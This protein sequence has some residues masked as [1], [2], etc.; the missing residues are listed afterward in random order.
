MFPQEW[1]FVILETK[2]NDEELA[3]LMFDIL[4]NGMNLI[5]VYGGVELVTKNIISMQEKE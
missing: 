5:M 1:F 2:P 3:N 4:R